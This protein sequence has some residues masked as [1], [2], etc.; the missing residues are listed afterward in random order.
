M[1]R[2]VWSVAFGTKRGGNLRS[3]VMVH[4]NRCLITNDPALQTGSVREASWRFL[5]QLQGE[6]IR[7]RVVRAGP[8]RKAVEIQT[9]EDVRLAK[10]QP[11]RRYLNPERPSSY[12]TVPTTRAA[13]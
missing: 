5:P 2:L 12:A 10:P 9:S 11:V 4:H 7:E 13:K 1:F 8:P 3:R 6:S